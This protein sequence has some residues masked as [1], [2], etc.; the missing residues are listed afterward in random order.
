M[1]N[2]IRNLFQDDTDAADLETTTTPRPMR[3]NVSVR[4]IPSAN[5]EGSSAAS[6]EVSG[7][8][9]NLQA[10]FLY[11]QGYISARLDNYFDA[12]KALDLPRTPQ[13]NPSETSAFTT[14]IKQRQPDD[15]Q[16]I[17]VLLGLV[18]QVYP[19]FLDALVQQALPKG[20]TDFMEFGGLR[21]TQHRGVL[22]TG[23]TL[24]F[25][26]AGNDFE[27]RLNLVKRIRHDSFFNQEHIVSIE[28]PKSGEPLMSGRL[29][30]EG[31]LTE[32]LLTD[33]LAM[34]KLS[35]EFPAQHIHTELEWS[36]LVLD[37]RTASQIDEI[38]HWLE[39]SH[40]LLFDWGM[41]KKVKPG[42]RALFYGPPGTGKTLTATLLGKFSGMDVFRIDLSMVVSKYIG[43]T[44][45]NLSNLFE[46]AENKNWILFFDEADALFGKR[47][48]VRDAHDKYANQEVAY[49]LQRIENYPGL[50]ILA[51][52]FRS[53]IDEAFMRR[54]QSAIYF[55]TPKPAERLLLWQKL[56]PPQM[57]LAANVDLTK[58]AYE[59]DLTGSNIINIIQHCALNVLSQ[60]QTEL[61]Q[62]VLNDGIIR[63]KIKISGA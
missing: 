54:F 16:L 41:H 57:G 59:H 9:G 33:T 35:M 61:S 15:V 14:F 52:N 12:S 53:N 46:R 30:L 10:A 48:G 34:P 29:A 42:Y 60:N 25:V 44:E 27:L 32:W 31:E 45:K 28:A 19:N 22:P 56:M 26:L 39:H 23:E 62:S 51:S 20:M 55:P 43:E 3:E 63:E 6:G 38:K 5:T 21:G 50:V 13:Y 36:D 40:T 37:N 18:P 2:K 24:L 11:L 49:L 8:D 1:F 4:E 17:A 47:T 58:V 7:L